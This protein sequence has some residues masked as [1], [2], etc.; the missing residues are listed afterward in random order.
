MRITLLG[1][2][3]LFFSCSYAAPEEKDSMLQKGIDLYKQGAYEQSIA[4]LQSRLKIAIEQRDKN[5]EKVIYNNLGNDYGSIGKTVEAL[6]AYQNA[7]SIA[8]ELKDKKSVAKC[9]KNIGALYAD[10]KDFDKA[11]QKYD[12]AEKIALSVNDT[13]TLA[14]CANNKGVVF[15]QQNKYEEAIKNY[16][17]AL[18]LYQQLKM[19]DRIAMLYNNLG[20]VYK[21]LKNYDKSIEFYQRSLAMSEQLG[22]KF[23]V[24]AN[25]IN[26]GNVYEMK[27]DYKKAIALNEQGLKTGQE[28]NSQELIINAYESLANDYAK[29]GDY[30]K[31][32]ELYKTYTAVKDSFISIERSKQ[33]AEMQTRYETEKK[34]KQ[35]IKLEK[36]RYQ[37]LAIIGIMI[38]ALV[39]AFLLYNRQ[40]TLQKQKREKAIADAEYNERMR[41]AKD[42][43][44]DL[45]SG[46]SK[47]SMM[48]DMAQRRVSG[49]ER[50]GSDMESIA[51]IS[52]HLTSLV[53]S[54][55]LAEDTGDSSIGPNPANVAQLVAGLAGIAQTAELAR[56]KTGDNIYLGNE[57]KH[58]STM[59][60][61]LVDNMRDLIWV[62]NP[63][64]TTLEQLVARLREYCGDYLEGMQVDVT[65]DFSDNVPALKISR[66]GQRNIFLTVKESVNNSIKHAGTTAM[67]ISLKVTGSELFIKVADNG[68]GFD[69]NNIKS[70]GNGLRNMKQRIEAV[71][72]SY[73]IT[74]VVGKGTITS[75]SVLLNKLSA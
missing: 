29:S 27:G 30:Q 37:M 41:I 10:T 59:S 72:G 20:I 64:N 39:I 34:E 75:V 57:I 12:E 52:K 23:M 22:D 58:I 55:A 5:V 62:L 6:K 2:F 33:L 53:Q 65:L 47:I 18:N 28:L 50:L 44:D 3:L 4:V 49:N 24:A 14:D 63:E 40:Q 7:I 32:F 54:L 66:E 13:F 45:G 26:I 42:V 1:I 43:H 61:E 9:T 35:I 36:T 71:G 56:K 15:E 38:L 21:Y 69:I 48:A 51:L 70:S 19:D 16:T 46:L 8:E 60:R 67:D 25:E 74:S 11:L 31:G 68:K 17:R 73:T